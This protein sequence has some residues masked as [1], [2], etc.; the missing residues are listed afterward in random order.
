MFD[1]WV[2]GIPLAKSCK[3][4]NLH[5]KTEYVKANTYNDFGVRHTHKRLPISAHASNERLAN[6]TRLR[7]MFLVLGADNHTA[8]D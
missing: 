6:S 3:A 7:M 5:N 2:L 4:L 8:A 1:R